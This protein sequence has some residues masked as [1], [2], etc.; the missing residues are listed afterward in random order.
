M[1]NTEMYNVLYFSVF[2]E[3]SANNIFVSFE[4]LEKTKQIV[5]MKYAKFTAFSV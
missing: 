3:K 4:R 2:K 5:I 1:Q